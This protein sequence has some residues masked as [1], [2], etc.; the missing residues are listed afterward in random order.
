VVENNNFNFIIKTKIKKSY[1]KFWKMLKC[2]PDVIIALHLASITR[3]DKDSEEKPANYKRKCINTFNTKKQTRIS[4]S[5]K[6]NCSLQLSWLYVPLLLIYGYVEMD[7]DKDRNLL[8]HLNLTQYRHD[9]RRP[10]LW[11]LSYVHTG[12][13][14]DSIWT[15]EM[16]S[17]GLEPRMSA[18]KSN[19]LR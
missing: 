10:C 16:F 19:F 6:I 15:N 11:F 2:W 8:L 17:A 5:K 13:K 1:V 18:C 12:W 4:C 9:L 7:D 3:S 14:A